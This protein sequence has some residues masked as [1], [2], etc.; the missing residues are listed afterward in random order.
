MKKRAPAAQ[1]LIDKARE[2]EKERNAL[3]IRVEELERIPKWC[4][5]YFKFHGHLPTT[6]EIREQFNIKD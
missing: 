4:H 5:E 3:C 1:A 6:M 2:I